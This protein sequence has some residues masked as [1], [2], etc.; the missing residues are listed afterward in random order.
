MSLIDKIIAYENG[1][2]NG[3]QVCKFFQELID[4]DKLWALQ[5]S[6]RRTAEFLIDRGFCS[7]KGWGTV[8]V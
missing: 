1:E 6:Y 2:M 5:G 3:E 8:E 7:P 4:T